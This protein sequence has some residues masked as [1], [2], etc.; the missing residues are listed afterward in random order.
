MVM[1]GVGALQEVGHLVAA[2]KCGVRV[3]GNVV[4]FGRARRE[5]RIGETRYALR[6][7]LRGGFGK[8]GGMYAPARTCR[9]S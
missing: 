6:A 1:W 8:C 9:R 4:V 2:R 7:V 3:P 5:R